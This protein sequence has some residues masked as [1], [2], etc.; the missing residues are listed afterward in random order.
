MKH[1][2][3]N[4]PENSKNVL[5]FSETFIRLVG[6]KTEYEGRLEVYKFGRWGTVCEDSVTDKLAVVVCRSLGFPW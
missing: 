3:Y 4:F 5:A 6:G 1:K 2:I